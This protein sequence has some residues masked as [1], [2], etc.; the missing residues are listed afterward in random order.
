MNGSDSHRSSLRKL[1]GVTHNDDL[2][3]TTNWI[4]VCVKKW[5]GASKVIEETL[6]MID[7]RRSMTTTMTQ[8]LAK[9][10]NKTK[11]STTDYH[12]TSKLRLGVTWILIDG[13]RTRK[14]WFIKRNFIM[15][16]IA[17]ENTPKTTIGT[18]NEPLSLT[19]HPYNPQCANYPSFRT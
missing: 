11:R 18:T 4:L 14:G 9:E 8:V 19:G 17:N 7:D 15:S 13:L 6:P 2:C 10:D 5:E 1:P 16:R 12:F 3:L